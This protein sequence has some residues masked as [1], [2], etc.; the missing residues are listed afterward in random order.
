MNRTFLIFC[1]MILLAALLVLPAGAVDPAWTVPSTSSGELSCVAISGDG[2]TVLAGGD[3]LIALSRDGRKLWTGWSGSR[4][5]ISRD[6]NTIL[7]V[8]DQDV[9]LISGSGNM[10]WDQSVEV[11][12]T[13]VTMLPDASM[14]A[15]AGTGRVRLIN[16]SGAGFRQNSSIAVN[17]IRFFPSGTGFV[18]TSRDGIQ[19]SNLTLFSQWA[20]TNVSQDMVEVTA[21]GSSFVSV[22]NNRVRMYSR[23]G[24]LWWDR[25]IPGGNALSFALSGDGSTIVVGRDDNTLVVLDGGGGDILWTAT[26]PSWV[27]S[28]AVSDDGSTIA[29]GCIGKTLAV[30]DRAG[31]NLGSA[32]TENPI[33]SQ[34]VAVTGDGSLIVAVDSGAV[35]GFSRSQ[36]GQPPAT[37]V[38]PGMT[39]SGTTLP[40]QTTVPASPLPVTSPQQ[41]TPSARTTQAD[42]LPAIALPAIIGAALLFCR[43]EP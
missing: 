35:Y 22:T 7:T 10:I 14:I 28:V 42:L 9:R 4:I 5:A 23:L 27:E 13:E 2:S 34:S 25:A 38:T 21:D 32:T 37:T 1:G 3:Q 11:P 20:D 26:E 19:T 17:H 29:A 43:R 31:T 18:F 40:P 16:R 24:S 15:A 41:V 30:Y 39:A 12:V 6:G 36:F 8:R 33:K